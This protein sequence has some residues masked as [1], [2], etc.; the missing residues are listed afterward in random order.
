MKMA[1]KSYMEKEI[2]AWILHR[3]I[4]I[5]KILLSVSRNIGDIQ[6]GENYCAILHKIFATIPQFEKISTKYLGIYF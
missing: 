5:N 6:N 3:S 2:I 4:F 1:L